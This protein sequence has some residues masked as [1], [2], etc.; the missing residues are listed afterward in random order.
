MSLDLLEQQDIQDRGG[1]CARVA[2]FLRKTGKIETTQQLDSFFQRASAV[3]TR[4]PPRAGGRVGSEETVR[5]L[6][7]LLCKD[8]QI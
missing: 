2:A 6:L 7:L 5:W 3:K 1:I 8:S 4:S